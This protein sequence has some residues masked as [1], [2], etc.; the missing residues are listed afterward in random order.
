[1]RVAFQSQKWGKVHCVLW[2]STP[3]PKPSDQNHFLKQAICQLAAFF[4]G[5]VH[6]GKGQLREGR[7]YLA[8]L[9]LEKSLRN[10]VRVVARDQARRLRKQNKA[11]H[12]WPND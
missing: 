5:K 8:I 3:G 4:S 10:V 9:R 6:K 2:A 7:K 12:T 11:V 1:M